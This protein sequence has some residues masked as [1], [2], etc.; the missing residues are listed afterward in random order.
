MTREWPIPQRIIDVTE[1]ARA[2]SFQVSPG[3]LANADEVIE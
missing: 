2:N 3:Y 1:I